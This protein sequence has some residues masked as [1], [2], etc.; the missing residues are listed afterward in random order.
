[1][2]VVTLYDGETI[3]HRVYCLD[4]ELDKTGDTYT[5]KDGRTPG[6]GSEIVVKDVPGKILF[7][8]GVNS[9]G[10]E[11]SGSGGGTSG[12][13]T[14]SVSITE[15]GTTVVSPSEGKIGMSQV[16]ITTNVEDTSPLV[17]TELP[18]DVSAV[19]HD[20][21]HISVKVSGAVSEGVTY[22]WY[23]YNGTDWV[24]TTVSGNRTDT[25]TMEATASRN[26][27]RYR[28]N[29]TFTNGM[30]VTTNAVTLTVE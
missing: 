7:W 6:D 20:T 19:L 28:C 4:E 10:Y 11:W 12:L 21:V 30:T 26:G 17:F 24:Q 25:I 3:R 15:N 22:Q 1:M 5:F 23:W 29:L 2:N 9:V 8:D 14:K 27:Y 13:E 16:T 18:S